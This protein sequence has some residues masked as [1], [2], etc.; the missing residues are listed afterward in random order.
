MRRLVVA[1]VT[2]VCAACGVKGPPRPP[3]EPKPNPAVQPAAAEQGR[4]R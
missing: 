4:D 1:L 3:M 2:A